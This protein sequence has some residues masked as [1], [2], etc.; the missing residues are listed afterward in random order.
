MKTIIMYYTFGGS[1]RKEAEKLAENNKEAVLCEIK[2]VK[3][4]NI[5][6]AFLSGCPGALKRNASNIKPIAYQLGNYE[7]I[8][9]VA[10][11]W[12]GF[13]VPAFN[14]MVNLLPKGK[15]VELFLCSAG[16]ETPKSIDGTKQMI[17]DKG[18]KL[19]GYHDIKT[20]K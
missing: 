18:C 2:E 8:I 5:I 14:A 11:V 15:E 9:L 19:V 13:P 12:A 6:T 17:I 16:G 10:P 7:R 4:K 20:A 1:S 3:K